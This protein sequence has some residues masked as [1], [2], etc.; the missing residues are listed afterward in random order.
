[1]AGKL[2][3]VEA[4]MSRLNIDILGLSEVRWPGSG[5]QKTSN[6]VIYYSG[7][8]ATNHRYGTAILVNNI[9]AE[10]VAE[11]IPLND[12]VMMLK[13][14]T[15]HRALNVIQVY[16]PT[17]DKTDAEMEDFYSKIEEAMRLTKRGEL[18]MVIGDF[19]AKV[20][21]GAEDTVGQYGLG[22]RNTRGDRLV[23]FCAE[24]NL[25]ITNTFFKQHPRRLY[26]WKSPADVRGKII[27]NQIDFIL[28]RTELRKYV[29]TVKTYPGA[30]INSDHNPVVM[31]F[32]MRRLTKVKKTRTSQKIDIRQLQKPD[33]QTYVSSR[34]E[35][36]LKEIQRPEQTTVEIERTWDKIKT[37]ITEIQVQD[38]GFPE[39][40]RKKEWM[41]TEIL[42][43]MTE[44][45]IQKPNPLLYKEINRKIRR[46]CREAKEQWMSEKCKEI[47][48]NDK[49]NARK[50][51]VLTLRDA[52]NEIIT[53]VEAKL[54][55]WKRYVEELFDDDRQN[56]P[57]Q[58]DKN[59]NE[60]GPEITKDEVVHAIKAQKNGKATGPD[61]VYAEVI[62]LIA[63]REGKGLDL[64]IALFN[65]IY[66]SGN[67][68]ADWLKSTFITLPKKTQ[69][70]RC[71]DYR[72]ISL[73][74]HVLKIF[75]RIIHTRIFKKCEYQLDETQ[76]GFR[77]GLGTREAL[78]SLNVLTQRCRDMNIN[79]F[80][81]F[82]D[83][84]KAFDCVKH[85]KMIEILRA[86]GIDSEEIR[87]ISNLYW[88]QT[89]EVRLESATSET[90]LI[91]KGVRQGC[92]LSLL[93]F[94]IY[95]EAIFKE[96]LGG[97]TGGIR[98]N[99]RTINNIKYADD[100]VVLAENMQD[101]QNMIDRIVRHSESFGLFMNTTKT[102]TMV[103]SKTHV[104]AH[105]IIKGATVEQVSFFKYLGTIMTS[106][107]DPKKE[108][109]SR[110]EQARRTFT[111]MKTFFTR[112][113][114]SLNLRVRMIR[115][116]IFSTL[117]YGC[118]SWT[119][120]PRSPQPY[121]ETEGTHVGN[122]GEKDEIYRTPDARRKIRTPAT[123]HP[124]QDSGEEIHR[125]AP[126]FLA[127]RHLKMVWLYLGGHLSHGSI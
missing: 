25:L 24:N 121:A 31:D 86:T 75:L 77:N 13:L 97:V 20:G 102:K 124:R 74:S 54:Q 9:V 39:V 67:I 109:R 41:T 2:A 7:G 88:Q 114:L 19:N 107:Y 108:I 120:D 36:E 63:D 11:F 14:Q 111:S 99:G 62:K 16:A 26:T 6:G 100:T 43:L 101:L 113:D 95:S 123:D 92:V 90:T 119:L 110:I 15:S 1:M 96:A 73:M 94:N 57:P 81:C 21:S 69:A 112:S 91:K 32:R 122:Q 76:F 45:R 46:K 85:H 37:T 116:Y 47:E 118:E 3:N 53:G 42:E 104:H 89:A 125:Q 17:N 18:T 48:G 106:L 49:G 103:F 23:Q 51:Q 29:Q 127:E 8:S 12:R 105:L 87:L 35:D 58:V 60:S 38:I 59:I 44:R 40:G 68:P 98:I 126:K 80:A 71:D 65:A 27:R 22:E 4:E 64:L 79:V 72:M 33:M 66:R 70:S 56:T 5:M 30:D 10:S 78:F 52:N 117:L 84:R 34:L 61:N 55:V 83:Y 115:C 28:I 50:H 82:I 93:L